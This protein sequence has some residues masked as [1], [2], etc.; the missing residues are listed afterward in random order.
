M[1]KKVV[2]T[3]QTDSVKNIVKIIKS[4]KKKN[5]AFSFK[6]EFVPI[7]KVSDYLKNNE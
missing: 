5:G 6:A 3:L 1:A 7:D 4:V 2:A